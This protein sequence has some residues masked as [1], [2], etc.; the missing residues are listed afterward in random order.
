[1]QWYDEEKN[2]Q[3]DKKINKMLT[4]SISVTFIIIIVLIFLIILLK[5]ED[6]KKLKVYI[7]GAQNKEILS[8]LDFEQDANGNVNILLPIKDI[9][10]YLGYKAYNGEYNNATEDTNK[11]YVS[12]IK[13]NTT[14][15]EIANYELN[16]NIL[17]KLDLSDNNREYEYLELDSKVIEK[18]NKLYTTMDGIEKGFNVSFEYDKEK[19][20]IT[21][22]TLNYLID[23]YSKLIEDGKY[24]SCGSL[25]K[26]NFVNEK[27]ILDG[28]LI[29]ATEGDSSS[30]KY[31]VLDLSTGKFILEEKYDGI[32]YFK[33]NSSFLV[34]SNKKVGLISSD[35]KTLIKPE[36]DNLSLIDA[37]NDLYLAKKNN[38]Y[39][40]LDGVGKEV[41]YIENEKVGL[42]NTN[43]ETNGI[44]NSYILLENLIPVKQDNKWALYDIKGTMLT[45]GFIYD[46]IG[47]SAT[48]GSNTYGLLILPE[49]NY[50]IAQ[51]DRKYSLLK[52][53]G[54]ELGMPF[55]FDSMYIKISSGERFYYMQF[56]K[57]EYDII[58]T[59]ESKGIYPKNSTTN[60]KDKNNTSKENTNETNK[61]NVKG[62]NNNLS[63]NNNT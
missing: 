3:K 52:E 44:K 51:K 11:C 29:V 62:A 46:N 42:D 53:N 55:S 33:F 4:A 39:G 59:L 45:N 18:N 12:A 63:E 38:L 17:Y 10:Q 36:Y 19:N 47:C 56:N 9:S 14:Y 54:K 5:K 50:I 2:K 61:N 57:K 16:S 13:E 21:I 26:E 23:W 31:G 1:M 15:E 7:D 6:G 41:I 20:Q 58:K 37:K 8:M 32:K 35:G 34:A 27:G 25:D 22:Y 28:F 30:K 40:V 43:Y 49:Y 60:T 24:G 48:N